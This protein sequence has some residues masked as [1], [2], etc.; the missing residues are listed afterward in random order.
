MNT[1]RSTSGVRSD[2]LGIVRSFSTSSAPKERR[3]SMWEDHNRT[4]LVDLRTACF[5]RDSLTSTMLNL[6]LQS[7]RL[8]DI[9]SN[10]H[11]IERTDTHI[12]RT[13][14][15]TVLLCLL[16]KGDASFFG[17]H[18]T[19]RIG[20][21]EA[22]LYDS[23]E[24]FMYGFNS[25]MR[26]HIFQIPRAKFRELTG[27]ER[28]PQPMVFGKAD[29]R[30]LSSFRRIFANTI[31]SSILR[32]TAADDRIEEAFDGLFSML[33]DSRNRGSSRA[34]YAMAKDFIVSN[35]DQ[36]GLSVGDVA[37]AVGVSERQ[38]SRVF[39]DQGI[40]VA[41]SIAEVRLAAAYDMLTSTRADGLSIGEIAR[42][43]GYIHLSHFS[44][45]FKAKYGMTARDVKNSL[46][47]A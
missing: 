46:S 8:T 44:R 47:S 40:G 7:M 28:L 41:E 30:P 21:S 17:A 38:L 22:I 4:A 19:V 23:D 16:A 10:D 29:E 32:Q 25:T 36:P 45:S 2:H 31:R 35:L 24:P 39:A 14:A 1:T 18:G 34:H 15:G 26:Q 37:S 5:A 33:L 42:R 3:I 9:A 27:R 20:S 43:V 13:P 12:G 11:V 6:P